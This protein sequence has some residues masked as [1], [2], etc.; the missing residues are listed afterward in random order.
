MN[1]QQGQKSHIGNYPKGWFDQDQDSS[2][3]R[4]PMFISRPLPP[5]YGPQILPNRV[6]RVQKLKNQTFWFYHPQ[7]FMLNKTLSTL[8]IWIELLL[9]LMLWAFTRTFQ[10]TQHVVLTAQSKNPME[11]TQCSTKDKF[12]FKK[13]LVKLSA[14]VIKYQ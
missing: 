9:V 11:F 8:S 5:K 13:L 10:K 2:H 12:I 6:H 4:V 3:C 7:N 14:S 1:K